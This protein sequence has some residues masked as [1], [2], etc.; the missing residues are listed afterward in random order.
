[1]IKT[2]DSRYK[3]SRE[4]KGFLC[5]FIDSHKASE[6]KRT[7][8]AAEKTYEEM[9]HRKMRDRNNDKSASDSIIV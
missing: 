1:M 4:L 2:K 6:F 9:R 3:M 8:I 5:G 7:M